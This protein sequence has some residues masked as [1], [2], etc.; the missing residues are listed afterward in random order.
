M[1]YVIKSKKGEQFYLQMLSF[2]LGD[3]IQ[4]CAQGGFENLRGHTMWAKFLFQPFFNARWTG[5]AKRC[6]LVFSHILID[7]G[8]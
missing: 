4:Y 1:W 8:A 2:P 3:S 5:R 7:M 6:T